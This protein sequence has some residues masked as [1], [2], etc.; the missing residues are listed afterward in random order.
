MCGRYWLDTDFQSIVDRYQITATGVLFTPSPEIFPTQTVP[1]IAAPGELTTMRW[2][3]PHPAGRGQIINA[4]GETVAQKPMFRTAFQRRR[5]LLP[6]SG[7]FEWQK[8]DGRS[9]RH[10]IGLPGGALFSLAGLYSVF[11]G[12]DGKSLTACTIIT[13]AANAAM[14]PIHDRMPVILPPDMETAWLTAAPADALRLQSLLV[15]YAGTLA[16]SA[17]H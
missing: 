15:P 6:A 16:I 11:P 10:R 3:F 8:A 17:A 9:I 5:C 4:R 13:A 12:P 1:A 7:F 2:G 14:A